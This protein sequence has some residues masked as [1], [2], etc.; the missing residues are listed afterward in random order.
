MP[1]VTE[2][3]RTD[4]RLEI[5]LAALRVFARKGFRAASMA[6]IIAESG[7]SAGAIYGH[8]RGKD[9]LIQAAIAEILGERLTDAL[10]GED[11]LGAH[12]PGEVVTR[13]V[14]AID[15][16]SGDPGILLQVW[17][18]AALD[19]SMQGVTSRVGE[20]L[21]GVFR[22]YLSVWYQNE[23][24]FSREAAV[25][26]AE[27]FAPL[28]VGIVQGYIVQRTIFS[29]FDGDGYLRAASSIRPDLA[30]LKS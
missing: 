14:R 7:L 6:D 23:L 8:Y 15:L 11:G 26:S 21:L 24:G 5:A 12:S 25:G 10:D 17:A 1:K 20:M 2:Q 18:Q 3:H 16:G 4:R 27:I 13:F 30:H 9:E 28:Y 22:D 19:P 29:E